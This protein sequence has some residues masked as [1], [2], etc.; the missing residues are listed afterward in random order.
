[1]SRQTRRI[2]PSLKNRTPLSRI[3]FE[4]IAD[5]DI[6]VVQK[7][8]EGH[9]LQEIGDAVG[10]TREMVRLIVSKN[11]G[12]NSQEV[13][14]VRLNRKRKEI[15]DIVEVLG[16]ADADEIA[17]TIG[18]SSEEV[19]KSLGRHAKKLM[20]NSS[21]RE[22]FYSDEELLGI[23][24]NAYIR[25]Q[26]PLTTNKYKKLNILPTIAVYISRFG[27]W[28]EAC[29]LA[30]VPHGKRARNNYSRA[31]SEEDMLDFVASYL[32]DPRT[33]G[34]AQGYEE[35]QKG[36]VGAPSLSLIR[37]RIGTWNEIKEIL[38]KRR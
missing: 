15:L 10:L 4:D 30:G 25:V 35:W 16:V 11:S 9:T 26:G 5:R 28:N 19:R 13:R 20:R 1:M 14:E 7:R 18:A 2:F 23:L 12:P 29:S 22:K 33:T 34:S 21:R 32:A 37:Q 27:S 36:V 3:Y 17:Q 8:R 6:Y 24:H 31:H 38:I